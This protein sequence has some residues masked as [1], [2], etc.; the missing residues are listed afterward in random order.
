[1]PVLLRRENLIQ[2]RDAVTKAYRSSGPA[3]RFRKQPGLF[4]LNYRGTTASEY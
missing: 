3:R 4:S 2:Q 1:L